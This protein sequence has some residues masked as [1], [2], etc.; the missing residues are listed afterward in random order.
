VLRHV[1]KQQQQHIHLLLWTRWDST[2]ALDT[3]PLFGS[4]CCPTTQHLSTQTLTPQYKSSR[5]STA[6]HLAHRT[7]SMALPCTV[8]TVWQSSDL[9][10]QW[11]KL[12]VACWRSIISSATASGLKLHDQGT[13]VPQCGNAV[14]AHMQNRTRQRHCQHKHMHGPSKQPAPGT[15]LTPDPNPSG[16]RQASKRSRQLDALIV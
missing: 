11:P 3:R 9:K 6:C 8:L 14:G 7:G 4:C 15:T 1:L 16:S 10:A 2:S 13:P 12:P 5:H